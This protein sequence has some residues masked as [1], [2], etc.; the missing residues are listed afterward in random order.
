MRHLTYSS[1]EYDEQMLVFGEDGAARRILIIPP[2]FDE[3]NRMRHTL[4]EAMRGLANNGI[5]SALP[6]FPGCNESLSPLEKQSLTGWRAAMANAAE[7]FAAS[8]IFSTR[9]GCLIDDFDPVVP[10][11]RLAPVKGKSLLNMLVRTRIAG[12]KE[13]GIKSS[14]EQLEQLALDGAV[15]LAG[16]AI[17][18]AMW[19]E[20]AAAEPRELQGVWDIKPKDINGSALWLRAEPQHSP[21]MAAGLAA[22]LTQWSAEA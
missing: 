18:A 22:L 11:A 20:L 10:T 7:Y 16:N 4:T 12:D 6:D 21:E 19:R 14:A 9:G 1:D 3:M 2:L 8:H 5:A 13:A 15:E 17:S